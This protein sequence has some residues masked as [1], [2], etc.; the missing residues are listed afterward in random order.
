[1][2]NKDITSAIIGS[3]FFAIPYIGIGVALLP[4][5][6]IGGVAFGAG[7]LMLSGIK[8]KATLKNTNI[9]LWKKIET[10]RHENK[11]IKELIPKVES[12]YTKT[13]LRE[14]NETVDKILKV[15]ENNKKKKKRLN[16]FFDY[17]LPVLIN[18][19]DKYDEIENQKLVSKEGT[20]FLRK[21]DK[22]IEETNKAFKMILSSLYQ[23]DIMDVEADLKVYDMMLKSD[24][25]LEDEIM[26]GSRD[27]E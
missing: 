15:V 20:E 21:A 7:E 22:M 24:G 27:N 11:E 8:P 6:I 2:K 23:K 16:N 10:A 9:S 19:V 18:I 14:I 3:A 13:N 12:E 25:I 1:M 4:S 17:Y 5:L 26:K